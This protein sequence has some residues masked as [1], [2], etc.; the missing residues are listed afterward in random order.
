MA[1]PSPRPQPKSLVLVV[2]D[3]DDAIDIYGSSLRHHGYEVISAPTL[4]E[5][6]AHALARR[7]DVVVL[8]CRLPDGDGIGLLERWRRP[9]SPMAKVPVIVVTASGV[10]QDV[11]AAM[12]AGAD[13]FVQKPCPGDV[14]AAYVE[15]ALRGT[16][17]SGEMRKVTP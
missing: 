5:A 17:R 6:R 15:R 12:A 13:V 8:D 1:S 3:N 9:G 4:E 10:R 2:E 14:L 11:S 16:F 7:P